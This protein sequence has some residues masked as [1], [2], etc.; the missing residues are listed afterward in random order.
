MQSWPHAETSFIDNFTQKAI[1][2]LG[3]STLSKAIDSTHRKL[4]TE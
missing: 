3:K 4:G 2:K 1:E